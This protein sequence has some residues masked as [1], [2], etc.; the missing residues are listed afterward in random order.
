MRH[1]FG[2]VSVY[3][4]EPNILNNDTLSVQIQW[5]CMREVSIAEAEEFAGDLMKAIEFA[6]QIKP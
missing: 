5:K 2:L 6:K 1:K 4:N 3:V